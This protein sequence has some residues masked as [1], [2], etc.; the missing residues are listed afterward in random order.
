M[1]NYDWSKFTQRIP[2]KAEAQKIYDAWA[3]PAGLESWFLRNAKFRKPDGNPR[4]PDDHIQKDDTYE[5]N[6][7]GWSDDTF[8]RGS[9]LEANGQDHFRFTFGKAG[10]VSVR[11]KTEESQMIVELLQEEIPTDEKSK[12][13]FH[14]GCS[15]GWTFYLANLKSIHEGGLDLRNKDERIKSV[16]NS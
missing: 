11:I 14:L 1:E 16:V 3:T 9:V 7:F 12:A 13:N 8:E 2:V 4:N 15:N 5:W 6:W 10:I